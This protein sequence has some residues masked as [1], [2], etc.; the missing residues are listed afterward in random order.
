MRMIA[1]LCL[2]AGGVAGV[3]AGDGGITVAAN[4]EA[5]A[6]IVVAQDDSFVSSHEEAVYHAARE[7]ADFLHQVTGGEFPIVAH[8]EAGR[9]CLFVGPH[10][11]RLADPAFSTAGL[12]TDGIVIRTVEK[13]LI[14]AGGEPRGT[15]YAVYTFLEDHVGCHWWTPTESTI[16]EKPTLTVPSLDV[17]YTPR[18]EYR[19][20]CYMHARDPDFSVRNKFNG[21]EH[22]LVTDPGFYDTREDVKRGGGK[23]S[24][25]KVHLWNY[26]T[27]WRFIPPEIY[28][29]EHPDWFAAVPEDQVRDYGVYYGVG[30]DGLPR[31]GGKTI[32]PR[33]LEQFI[34][35]P[36]YPYPSLCLTNEEMRQELVRSAKLALLWHPVTSWLSVSQAD[37]MN[38]CRCEKCMAVARE[39]GA[40]SGLMVRFVNAV[41]DDLAEWTAPLPRYAAQSRVEDA[42]LRVAAYFPNLTRPGL[43]DL[44]LV[45]EAYHYTRKP[46]RHARPR[47]NVI[48]LLATAYDFIKPPPDMSWEVSHGRPVTAEGNAGFREDFIGWSKICNRLYIWYYLHGQGNWLV[49][50]PNLRA[51]APDLRFFADHGVKGVYGEAVTWSDGAEL[52]E[53]RAWLW[54]KLLWN[55]EA[56]A[57]QL[58]AQFCHGYYGAAGEHI[59]AYLDTVH[60]AV[61]AKGG[62]L[63]VGCGEQL[64]ESDAGF[65]T[66]DILRRSWSCLEAAEVAVNDDPDLRFRVQVAQLPVLYTFMMRWEPL[67]QQAK[68]AALDWSLPDS[69]DEV[70]GRF[71]T[72]AKEIDM[73][74][75]AALPAPRGRTFPRITKP[76]DWGYPED[77]G[78][79]DD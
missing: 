32:R 59:L 64:R 19:S 38:P 4:G 39:E 77:W 17:R 21:H 58:I 3:A 9:D 55:P 34:E 35:R 67:R 8:P 27:F 48:V 7:L 51:I 70:Y 31:A 20:T 66:L 62:W 50:F 44:P 56:D 52:A 54:A 42:S 11:A 46:P 60:D 61:E 23:Y 12:G 71:I 53:L 25:P 40:Y 22:R 68:D 30:A 10:A 79:P 65:L 29:A 33:T 5:R 15:L 47:D 41:A 2:V 14:L 28:L 24:F 76:E 72:L 78:S 26:H 45:V 69:A 36:F 37:G 43:R 49:P 63:P 16:P 73:R 57:E 6:V 75:L 74:G 18:F 1:I 13:G